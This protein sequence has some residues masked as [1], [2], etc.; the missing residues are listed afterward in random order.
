MKKRWLV[1]IQKYAF[2]AGC[3]FFSV[4]V[5]ADI[6]SFTIDFVDGPDTH[7]TGYF[8]YDHGNGGSES[9]FVSIELDF[10]PIETLDSSFASLTLSASG[11]NRMGVSGTGGGARFYFLTNPSTG[12]NTFEFS[13]TDFSSPTNVFS[14]MFVNPHIENFSASHGSGGACSTPIISKG[15]YGLCVGTLPGNR[16]AFESGRYQISNDVSVVPVPTAV[17]LFGSAL[18]SLIVL[19]KSKC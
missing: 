9:G 18:L 8:V 14:F 17:L 16:I 10:S 4:V 19:R 1:E 5:H 6:V 11:L 12:I 3:S 15:E 13:H 7:G 2:V